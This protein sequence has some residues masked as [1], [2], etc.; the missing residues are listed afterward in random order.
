[1]TRFD[2]DLHGIS[3]LHWTGNGFFKT[4]DLTIYYSGNDNRRQNGVAF[5]VNKKISAAVESYAAVS[6]RILSIRLRG[7]PLNITIFQ[8]Y[9]PTSA[10]SEDE[11][12]SFY[13]RLVESLHQMHKKDTVYVIGDF[14]AKIGS[15]KDLNITGG[16]GL[17]ERNDAGDR[18]FQFFI[19]NQLRN[20]NTF[21]RTTEA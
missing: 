11:I 15:Q 21:F 19:K 2:I 20:I 5:I 18:L 13:S 14:N 7:K 4:D 10:A 16:F 3:E 12:E 6:D 17:G 1:M 8:V 9:A